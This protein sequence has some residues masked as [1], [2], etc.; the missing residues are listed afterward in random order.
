MRKSFFEEVFDFVRS[1]KFIKQKLAGEIFKSQA[2]DT[3]SPILLQKKK[4]K[5]CKY[6]GGKVEKIDT[7]IAV[8][9][10]AQLRN[11]QW[12]IGLR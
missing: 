6:K 4:K 10:N 5:L 2:F 12:I 1:V 9:K 8:E 3:R 11:R 7:M